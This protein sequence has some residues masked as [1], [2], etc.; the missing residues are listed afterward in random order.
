MRAGR[1]DRRVNLWCSDKHGCQGVNI[2]VLTT[3]DGLPF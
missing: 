1:S 2:Q 3:P